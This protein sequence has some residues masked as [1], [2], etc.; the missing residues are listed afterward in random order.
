MRLLSRVCLTIHRRELEGGLLFDKHQEIG[1][2]ITVSPTAN[3]DRFSTG[4]ARSTKK[5]PQIQLFTLL[6]H[7]Y[8]EE[9]NIT[10]QNISVVVDTNN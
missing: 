3:H 4:V 5:V 8:K 6:P 2:I 9:Y 1:D 10:M 7:E